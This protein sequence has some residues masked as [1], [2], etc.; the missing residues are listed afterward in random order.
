VRWVVALSGVVLVWLAGPGCAGPPK[1]EE[2]RVGATR[3]EVLEAFGAP[4]QK[5]SFR[6]THEAIWGPIEDFWPRV[7]DGSSVDV[8]TYRVEGGDLELYFVDGSERVQGLGF[9]PEGAV[10]EAGR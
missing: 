7:P 3:S 2:F 6:K 1:A 4:L 10:F 5:Q 9:A 8:W